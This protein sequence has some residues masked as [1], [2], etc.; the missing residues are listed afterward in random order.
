MSCFA[1]NADEMLATMDAC[2]DLLAMA[3]PSFNPF[4]PFLLIDVGEES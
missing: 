3:R 4:S 2:R 1:A